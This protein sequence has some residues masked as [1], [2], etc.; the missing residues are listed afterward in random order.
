MYRYH[1]WADV[2]AKKHDHIYALPETHIQGEPSVKY[3][4]LFINDEEPGLNGW[5]AKY[6]DQVRQPLNTDFYAHVFDLLLRLKANYLWPAMWASS[7]PPPG[8][9]FFTDDPRNQALANDYGIVIA[10]SHHEPM[11]RATNEWNVSET[12]AWDWAENRDNV[13]VFMEEGVQRAGNNE[14]YFTLGMR[15]L[16]DE[17]MGAEDAAV[18]LAEVFEVQREII[19]KYH[20]AKDAVPRKA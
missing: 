12:G 4:G 19:E 18:V 20:G 14:S 8:N 5:W 11:H 17:A 9:I 15:G 13:T 1:F 2:P 16:G 6:N 7:T 3:R 10:T